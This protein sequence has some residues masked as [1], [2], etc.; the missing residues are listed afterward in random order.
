[1]LNAPPGVPGGADADGCL[2]SGTCLD[3]VFIT[4]PITGDLSRE[5]QTVTEAFLPGF[6]T[7]RKALNAFT[8]SGMNISPLR[9][10]TESNVLSGN[11]ERFSSLTTCKTTLVRP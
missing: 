3:I 11:M 10:T 7:L 5:P 4:T 9:Q 8:G 2:K 6:K 1:M